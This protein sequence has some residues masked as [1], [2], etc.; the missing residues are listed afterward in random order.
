[1]IA[2]NIVQD[3]AFLA[4]VF[5]ICAKNNIDIHVVSVSASY[6]NITLLID[7][8]NKNKAVQLLHSSLFKKDCI[9]DFA[10]KEENSYDVL[11]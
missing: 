4:S 6:T 5:D 11:A 10:K 1:V 8:K 9:Q 7:D 3:K 2:K